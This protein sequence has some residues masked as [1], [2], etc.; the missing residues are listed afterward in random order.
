[1]NMNSNYTTNAMNMGPQNGQSGQPYG[2]QPPLNQGMPMPNP[3]GPQGSD[4]KKRKKKPASFW[5]AIALAVVAVVIACLFAFQSCS[6]GGFPFRD[7]NQSLGQLEGKSAEEIQAEL[8][9]Q[10][11]EGMFNISIAS[12]VEFADG[13]SEGELK[14]ENVPGNRYLMQVT[15]TDDATGQV[16]YTSG[17]IDPNHHVQRA[18]LDVDLDPGVYACTALFTAIDPEDDS[19]VGQAAAKMT[20]SVLN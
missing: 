8:D 2:A 10:V 13:T 20:I 17:A 11:E 4:D 19:E 3:G 5:V 12:N 16:L 9:R 18:K 15:I 14:I 1:M 7:P 6:E